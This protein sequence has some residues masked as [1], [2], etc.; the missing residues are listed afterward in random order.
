MKIC[1]PFFILFFP[2]GF[3][4]QAKAGTIPFTHNQD[5]VPNALLWKVSGNG[6]A[7]DSYL[8]GTLHIICAGDIDTPTVFRN[9][10]YSCSRLFIEI[11]DSS[12]TSDV[13]L[14][15][16]RTI[17]DYIGKWYYK[18]IA[19]ALRRIRPGLP[20]SDTAFT[21][22][23]YYYIN[24]VTGD[25]LNCICVAYEE[26]LFD[27]AQHADMQIDGLETKEDRTELLGK[28]LSFEKM[29]D[30]LENYMDMLKFGIL[31]NY[32]KSLAFYKAHNITE[33]YRQSAY[34]PSG[35]NYE[36]KT[37]AG[38]KYLDKRN[39]LWVP[40]MQAAM[41][42]EPC[43]FAFGCAHMAGD[44]GVISLLR[45]QGYTVTPVY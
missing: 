12:V 8:Y 35:I 36:T 4:M 9:S 27:M 16:G 19:K 20:D 7:K 32:M 30:E 40:R 24:L 13:Y 10:L 29:G 5:T 22:K 41:K 3:F 31:K 14:P 15:P 45:Q 17:K 34:R 44:N 11:Q 2:A 43:F 23:P 6:L 37:Q 33:L 1:L 18:Q 28:S 39:V 42:K 21:F 38:T 25:A 26:V